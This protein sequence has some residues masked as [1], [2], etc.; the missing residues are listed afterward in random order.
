MNGRL[1]VIL[2]LSA[3]FIALLWIWKALT[4]AVGLRRVPDLTTP[5]HNRTPP[6]RPS[7]AVIIPA[8][9]EEKSIAACLTSLLQQD[10]AALHLIAV[11]DRSTDSTGAIINALATQHPAKLT[12]LRI[13]ELPT[14]WL[15]KTHA[16]AFAARHAISLH[17][18]DYLLFTDADIF[19][20]PETLRLAL[21]QTV[22]TQADHFVL[23]PTATIKSAGEG[24]L[25]SYLQVM[26]LWAVR[27]WRISDP[28][29]LR[30]A[31]GV[32]AFNLLR[33]TVYQQLG[34]FEAL[35]MEIVEDLALG[36][37]IKRQGFR[38]RIA[39]GPG[40]VNVHWASGVSGI[41]N[42]MTKNFFAI[43][44]YNPAL[45][46]LSCLSITVFCIA[47]VFFVALPNTRIAAIIT[48]ASVAL[49][50]VL[51]SRKSRVSPWYAVLFPVSAALIVSSIL[52]SMLTTLKQGGVTWRGTFYPLSE[53]RK[54]SSPR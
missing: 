29:A 32:G 42:G 49:L 43:F 44:H 6:D 23:L 9:N 27:T 37:R 35:R 39:T 25:L 2:K 17:H 1:D 15:G 30:D 51:S 41:L 26:S 50:Y 13:T 14:G 31:V 19:F 8:C 53:L 4:S 22:T 3:W 21:A 38:Q 33:T 47:P 7:I 46:L 16:M 28:K 20:R 12:A 24:M 40:L 36:T 10:Y 18:P 48:L 45:V 54:K 11:D 34:G 5:A 52:R